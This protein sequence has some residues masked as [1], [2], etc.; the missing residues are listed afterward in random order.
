M[1]MQH[2]L[3]SD[4]AG[5]TASNGGQSNTITEPVIPVGEGGDGDLKLIAERHKGKGGH[6]TPKTANGDMEKNE[7]TGDVRKFFVCRTYNSGKFK[8]PLT[9]LTASNKNEMMQL[10]R[11]G[12][13][14][15]TV[16]FIGRNLTV[17][18]IDMTKPGVVASAFFDERSDNLLCEG[19]QDSSA[20]V[21]RPSAWDTPFSHPT[22]GLSEEYEDSEDELY[23]GESHIGVNKL[24]K[25]TSH[26]VNSTYLPT[27]LVVAKNKASGR[28]SLDS[29]LKI[30]GL[31]PYSECKYHLTQIRKAH[32][33]YVCK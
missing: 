22:S 10:L 12:K 11:E 19:Q 6:D 14:L 21:D 2:D 30:V 26:H 27:T 13:E 1:S 5:S 15:N 8:K 24:Y 18:E 3:P 32:D 4:E 31:K 16:G 25:C 20:G 17:E 9:V 28:S 29:F 33:S 23:D 7:G